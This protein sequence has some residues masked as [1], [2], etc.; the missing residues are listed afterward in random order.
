MMAIGLVWMKPDELVGSFPP[1]S[2]RPNALA[3]ITQKPRPTIIGNVE[4]AAI[5]S[6]RAEPGG[7]YAK[8]LGWTCPMPLVNIKLHIPNSS[9]C[10]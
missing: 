10:G 2:D 7:I 4:K 1:M 5:F 3:A 9:A 8:S 6:R